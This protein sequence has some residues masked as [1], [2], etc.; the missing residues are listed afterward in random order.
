M[1]IDELEIF[2]Q[3]GDGG[4]GAV[5]FRREKYIEFGGPDGG[6][7]G[8]GGDVYFRVRPDFNTLM[9][10]RNQRHYRAASG[11]AG[12]GSNMTGACGESLFLEVPPGTLIRDRETGALLAD[13]TETNGEVIIAKGGRGGK[14]NKHFAS[15]TQRAPK[16]AQE[17]EKGEEF[18]VRLELKILADVGLVGFPNAGKSTLIKKMSSAKPKVADYPFTTLQPNLGVVKVSTERSFVVADIPGII[19]GA[20]EGAGLGLRFLRHI[21]RTSL[22]LM[23]LDTSDQERGVREAYRILR[24]ELAA[25]S[26]HL[27]AKPHC[28]AFNKIDMEPVD[29]EAELALQR[30]LEA[31]GIP[32]FRISGLVGDGVLPMIYALDEKV[33]AQKAKALENDLLPLDIDEEP[34]SENPVSRDPLDEI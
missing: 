21:E 10:L 1:F 14:G 25:F 24:T 31:V 8:H 23:V 4:R 5:S 18:W 6:D 9:P 7:G 12:R 34:V 13:L 32:C 20:H 29:P 19:E 26:K 11:V 22:L 27:N 3:A 2:I 17:G 30:E 16:F 33:R 28:V 15:S